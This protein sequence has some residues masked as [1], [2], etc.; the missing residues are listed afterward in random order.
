MTATG[1][2]GQKN[3]P[4]TKVKKDTKNRVTGEKKYNVIDAAVNRGNK[5]TGR[6]TA[7]F[8][9]QGDSTKKRTSLATTKKSI[10]G[11]DGGTDDKRK[12]QNAI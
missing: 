5:Q 3:A 7:Q 4:P 8:A 6:R 12:G 10:D 2:D 11:R 9:G 1:K